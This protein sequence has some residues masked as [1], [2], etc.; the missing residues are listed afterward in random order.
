MQFQPL[1][2]ILRLLWDENYIVSEESIFDV[3]RTAN[4]LQFVKVVNMC[5]NNIQ[6]MLS[7]TNC[8]TVWETCD[9][10]GIKDLYLKAKSM[11]LMEFNVIKDTDSIL[12]MNLKN[13]YQ[14][15]A[16]RNLQCENEM[17]VFQTC[18][19]WWY[20]NSTG[21]NRNDT[22][23]TIL[24]CVNFQSLSSSDIK[25][26]L[27]YPDIADNEHVSNI[28]SC[29]LDIRENITLEYEECVV[30]R[31]LVLSFSQPRVYPECPCFI[32]K[33]SRHRRKSTKFTFLNED[34]AIVTY[35]KLII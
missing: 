18:M 24:T 30:N 34:T 6:Q 17:V 28:L 32:M 13:L 22:L 14:Y 35:G 23:F 8:L 15:L 3:L 33:G 9:T 25:E 12:Y 1:S 5:V 10:L 2:S 21:L 29:V 11:A 7:P 19:K 4:M 16:N 31:A 26:I 20:E 27:S